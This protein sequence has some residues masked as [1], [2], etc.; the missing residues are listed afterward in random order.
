[1][2]ADGFLA[3]DGAEEEDMDSSCTCG[4]VRWFMKASKQ[5]GNND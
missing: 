3:E 5:C 1:M 2:V 4:P